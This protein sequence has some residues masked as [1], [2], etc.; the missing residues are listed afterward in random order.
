[1]TYAITT[2]M[3]LYYLSNEQRHINY[4]GQIPL[5]IENP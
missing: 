5:I 4:E 3:L 1:M 2:L